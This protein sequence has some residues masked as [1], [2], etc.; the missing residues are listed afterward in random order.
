MFE[1]NV[2]AYECLDKRE[3][4][5]EVIFDLSR[6]GKYTHRMF[7]SGAVSEMK[8]IRLAEEYLSEPISPCYFN[9]IKDD[10]FPG[11]AYENLRLRGDAL[12]DCYF[13]ESIASKD[14]G[15]GNRRITFQCGS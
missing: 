14:I 3:N 5:V 1:Y 7:C 15:A 11:V 10:L 8:A 2:S 6:Y 13:L 12:G 9:I 4:V